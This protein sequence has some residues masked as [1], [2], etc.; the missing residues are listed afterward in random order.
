MSDTPQTQLEKFKKAA[1][2]L[3]TD[4]DPERFEARLRKIARPKP[5]PEKT[6]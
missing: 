1:R 2:G 4:D 6:E 5:K 3:E